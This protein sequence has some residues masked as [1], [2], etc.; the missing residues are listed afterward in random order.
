MTGFCKRKEL[1][2]PGVV[3]M[4]TDRSANIYEGAAGVRS[5]G[6]GRRPMTADSVFA[7]FSATKPITGTA[8]LQS[9]RKA[10]RP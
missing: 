8:A 6:A 10:A 9:S 5:L 4:I 2:V 7:I 1:C 3:A